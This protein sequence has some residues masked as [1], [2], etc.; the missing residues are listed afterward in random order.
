MGLLGD[1]VTDPRAIRRGCRYCTVLPRI[2]VVSR[3]QLFP[4]RGGAYVRRLYWG[5][6]LQKGVS[7]QRNAR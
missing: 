3:K 1:N 4:E 2:V 7:I 5:L 6:P